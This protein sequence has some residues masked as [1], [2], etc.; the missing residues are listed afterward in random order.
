LPN[1]QQNRFGILMNGNCPTLMA[2]FIQV[3]ATTGRDNPPDPYSGFACGNSPYAKGHIM[4]LELGGPDISENIVPQFGQWQGVGEWRQMEVEVANRYHG[5][6]FTVCLDYDFNGLDRNTF[7]DP[8]DSGQGEIEA[9]ELKV[10]PTKFRVRVLDFSSTHAVVTGLKGLLGKTA[11]NTLE[12]TTGRTQL[13]LL[14]GLGGPVLFQHEFSQRVMPEI[15]K[16]Y[17][18]GQQAF[19]ELSTMADNLDDFTQSVSLPKNDLSFFKNDQQMVAA[20]SKFL[21]TRLAKRKSKRNRPI[22]SD[23]FLKFHVNSH[24]ALKS[25]YGKIPQRTMKMLM[26]KKKSY[27]QLV[28]QVK[29]DLG[30]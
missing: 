18:L 22:W 17:W 4:A 21:R 11:L 10:I 28:E 3:V 1:F 24:F 7:A 27:K 5:H 20:S 8:W 2:G 6:F 14:T 26:A 30:L 25:R 9:W 15:D 13:E 12:W 16:L 29:L 19:E 23:P